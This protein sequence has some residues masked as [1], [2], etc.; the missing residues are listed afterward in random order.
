M[1]PSLSKYYKQ[2]AIYP[3]LYSVGVG[4]TLAFTHDDNGYKSEWFKNDGFGQTVALTIALS[5][6]ISALSSTLFFNS[7]Q[8]IKTNS[9]FSFLSWTIP[10]ALIC[11]FVIYQELDNFFTA[12]FGYEGNRMLDGYIM[13]VALVHLAML[14][15][16]YILF[17]RRIANDHSG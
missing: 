4:A 8:L 15:T 1:S 5:I 2:A 6:L 17:R 7:L 11:L 14:L 13:S 3:F 10:S 16:T 9:F 12:R